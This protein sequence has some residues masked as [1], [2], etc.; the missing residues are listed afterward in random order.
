MICRGCLR[1]LCGG[2]RDH[3]LTITLS[4]R[5]GDSNVRRTRREWRDGDGR[6]QADVVWMCVAVVLTLASI[7]GVTM[8][9]WWCVG[10]RKNTGRASGIE[11][12]FFA[13][14]VSSPVVGDTWSGNWQS[15]G[16]R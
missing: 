8:M 4:S 15:F 7:C 13:D 2:R 16:L 10:G 9:M 6:T 3:D 5:R 14:G 12:T 1:R 11:P